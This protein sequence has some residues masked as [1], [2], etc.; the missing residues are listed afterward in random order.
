MKKDVENAVMSTKKGLGFVEALVHS[1]ILLV[2]LMCTFMC[3]WNLIEGY[4]LISNYLGSISRALVFEMYN[5]FASPVTLLGALSL[6]GCNFLVYY[7]LFRIVRMSVAYPWCCVAVCS[8]LVIVASC[9]LLI[10]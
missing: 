9:F 2:I 5:F 10:F 4:R 8:Q 3:F 7:I 1:G 6:L